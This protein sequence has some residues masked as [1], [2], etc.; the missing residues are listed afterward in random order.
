MKLQTVQLLYH[1]YNDYCCKLLVCTS[2][3]FLVWRFWFLRFQTA[4]YDDWS[5]SFVFSLSTFS[6]QHFSR[7]FVF[8]MY[9]AILGLRCWLLPLRSHS[10]QPIASDDQS[11]IPLT[12]KTT[13]FVAY[14]STKILLNHGHLLWDHSRIDIIRQQRRRRITKRTVRHVAEVFEVDAQTIVYV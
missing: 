11:V 5:L 10:S 13:K 7:S 14:C 6:H 9:K 4:S 2:V 1:Y 12:S 3:F 8:S